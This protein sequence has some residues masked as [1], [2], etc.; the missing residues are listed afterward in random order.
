[1]DATQ[2]GALVVALSPAKLAGAAFDVDGK[3]ACYEN[4]DITVHFR[5]LRGCYELQNIGFEMERRAVNVA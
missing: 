1:M 2:F 4:F 5:G 3:P